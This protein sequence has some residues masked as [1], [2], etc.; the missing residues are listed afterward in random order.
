MA[1]IACAEGAYDKKFVASAARLWA[2]TFNTRP[3]W[4]RT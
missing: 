3:E 4:Q 2:A 1:L